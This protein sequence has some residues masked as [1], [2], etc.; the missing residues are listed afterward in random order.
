MGGFFIFKLFFYWFLLFKK[1]WEIWGVL[2][3]LKNVEIFFLK[4]FLSKIV[5]IYFILKNL[6][7]VLNFCGVLEKG[8]KIFLLV[9]LVS[10]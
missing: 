5:V 3:I 8:I 4:K 7:R 10:L 6:C 2:F 1:F 9:F